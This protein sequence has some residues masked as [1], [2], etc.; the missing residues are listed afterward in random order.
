MPMDT[1]PPADTMPP[2]PDADDDV[3]PFDEE[4]EEAEMP[5]E[6]SPFG[7]DDDNPFDF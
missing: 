4:T 1:E 3:S 5:A 2:E 6:D 7:V